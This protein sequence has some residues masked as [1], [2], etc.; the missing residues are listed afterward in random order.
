MAEK[1][2][3]IENPA[4]LSIDIGRVKI[5]SIEKQT[6]NFIA[7]VDIACLIISNPQVSLTA[8]VVSEVNQ[9]AGIV[10]FTNQNYM[11]T[12]FCF[13]NN[14]N[15]KGA[16]RP[17]LQAQN[18]N[19]NVEQKIWQ[20]VIQSKIAGQALFLNKYKTKSATLLESAINYVEIG[21]STNMEAQCAK[22]YWQDYFELFNKKSFRH[23]QGASDVINSCLNYGYTILRSAVARSLASLGLQLSFGVGHKRVDNPFNLVEDMV[24]PFRYMI[25]EIVYNI[26]ND[27]NLLEDDNLFGLDT[28]IKKLLINEIYNLNISLNSKQYRFLQGVHIVNT[29]FCSVLEK[30]S[31]NLILPN[32]KFK[33]VKKEIEADDFAEF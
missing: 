9:N 27:N 18:I 26:V 11:P 12:S 3:T 5:Y 30:P 32:L 4:K 25:D 21:D 22:A 24:E 7:C 1:I 17:Y 20:Q 6:T 13:S 2:I 29:S 28:K 23:K 33:G 16:I 19:S 10:V 14:L 15:N 8:S 31:S